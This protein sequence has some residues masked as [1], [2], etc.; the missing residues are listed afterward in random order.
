MYVTLIVVVIPFDLFSY[1]R[2]NT[3]SKHNCNKPLGSMF[4]TPSTEQDLPDPV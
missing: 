1:L 4:G 3:S 2:R